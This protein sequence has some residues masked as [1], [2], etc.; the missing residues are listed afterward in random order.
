VE[1]VLPVY[2][3][4]LVFD[5]LKLRFAEEFEEGGLELVR[6]ER[7][8]GPLGKVEVDELVERFAAD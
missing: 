6:V 7:L 2:R 8:V 5:A 1:L 3:G 4:Y